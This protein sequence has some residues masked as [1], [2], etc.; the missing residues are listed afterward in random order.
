MTSA[1]IKDIDSHISNFPEST[2]ILLNQLRECI[3]KA[4]PKATECMNY[5]IPTFQLFGNLVHFA[6]Y[7]NHIGFYPGADGIKHFQKELSRYKSA[8]GSVQFPLNEPLPLELMGKIVKYR[9]KMNEEKDRIK[10]TKTCRKGH[11]FYKS[12][13]CPTCPKCEKER[14]K[15]NPFFIKISAPAQRALESKGINSLYQLSQFSE[16]EILEIHGMGKSTI[17][18]L[19][20]ALEKEN[21]SFKK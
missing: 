6:G 11:V 8:K 1:A 21:L 19:I 10:N 2:Q 12:S 9:V 5:G 15:V 7:K 4:A 18:V 17:P 13:S 20:N 3:Q 16:K 14:Q